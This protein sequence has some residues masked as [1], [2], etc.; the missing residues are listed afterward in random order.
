MSN[1]LGVNRPVGAPLSALENSIFFSLLTILVT[2]LP[3][4]ETIFGLPEIDIR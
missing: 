2:A 4:T 1:F 3:L